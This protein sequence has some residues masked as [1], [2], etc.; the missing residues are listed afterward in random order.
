MQGHFSFLLKIPEY[1][2]QALHKDFHCI[3][4]Y[5]PAKYLHS[6]LRPDFLSAPVFYKLC[7]KSLRIYFLKNIFV[8]SSI[9]V[10][11]ILQKISLCSLALSR[12]SGGFQPL[13]SAMVIQSINPVMIFFAGCFFLFDFRLYVG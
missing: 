3:P 13:H 12:L 6:V 5:F 9:Y 8:F 4:V 1:F 2:H 11:N 10:K 7:G